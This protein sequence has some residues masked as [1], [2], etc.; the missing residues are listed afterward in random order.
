MNRQ[1]YTDKKCTDE[2][3]WDEK[4]VDKNLQFVFVQGEYRRKT[5]RQKMADKILSGHQGIRGSKPRNI[6]TIYY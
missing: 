5:V 2:K 3:F 4:K 6:V 1:K